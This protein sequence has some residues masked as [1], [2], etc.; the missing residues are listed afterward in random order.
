MTSSPSPAPPPSLPPH[1]LKA[2]HLPRTRAPAPET[3]ERGTQKWTATTIISSG[4]Y[5]SNSMG[6]R[7][8]L[9]TSPKKNI[10][11]RFDTDVVFI[12]ERNAKPEL[13]W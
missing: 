2:P 7:T 8:C 5:P 13:S 10:S 11:V 4:L 1:H 3:P 12:Q 6:L 9:V